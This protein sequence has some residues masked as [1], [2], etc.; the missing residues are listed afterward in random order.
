MVLRIE[1]PAFKDREVLPKRFTCDGEDISPPLSWE[2]I[3]EGTRSL[4][5]ICDDPDAPSTTW[6]HW[7]IFNIDPL[8]GGIQ[9]AVSKERRLPEGEIHG[10]NSWGRSDYGGPCPPPGNP[11]RYFFKLYALDTRLSLSPGSSKSELLESMKKH[12][13]DKAQLMGIYGR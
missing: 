2:G 8:K 4:A 9:E 3:P 13:L 12:I 6:D 10:K 11:H 7:I 1:S 5:I